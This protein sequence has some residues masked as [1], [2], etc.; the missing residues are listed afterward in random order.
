VANTRVSPSVTAVPVNGD[1][2]TIV[3][4]HAVS[5]NALTLGLWQLD[6]AWLQKACERENVIVAGDF[7]ATLDNF[8]GL[9]T[10]GTTGAH[11]G[12]CTDAAATTQNAGVGTWPAWAPAW[13]GAPIDHVMASPSWRASAF[14]VLTDVN[15]SGADHRPIVATLSPVTP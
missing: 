12:S 11:L 14:R 1:G 6:L 5:P 13:V 15:T 2:P 8:S 9:A 10:P 4:V 3:A 7:N